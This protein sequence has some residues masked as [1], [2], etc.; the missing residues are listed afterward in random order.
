MNSNKADDAVLAQLARQKIGFIGA[1]R[2]ARAL[3]LALQGLG[4]NI[5]AVAS[6]SNDSA[7]ALADSLNN[8]RVLSKQ[9]LANVADLV[10][11][12]TPDAAI[13]P[14]VAGLNWHQ[15]QAVVHCSGA[16]EVQVLQPAA[17]CGALIGGFHPMQSFGADTRAAI[18]SLPGCAIAIEASGQ[19]QQFLFALAQALAC[20]PISLP[21]GA[22][23]R[24]HASGG[25]AA[26]K[27][28]VMLAEAIKLWLSW[29]ASEEQ[30][31]AALIPLLRGTV[32]S[33]ANS[34]V[35]Q[36]MPGPIS[37]GD[38]QT[39][40]KHRQALNSISPV[41]RANY[42]TLSLLAVDLAEQAGKL[43]SQQLQ[44]LR[45]VLKTDLV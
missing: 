32:E 20:K 8:C 2:L 1:G 12:S 34:G 39:V 43:D 11:I 7:S 21:A 30:A 17:D 44:Q 16:T 15:G 25:Y 42:D 24:Y 38:Y 14:T 35:A 4:L 45:H 19:L 29:G 40:A 23:A 13:E 6:R 18:A 5:Y 26:D 10:F 31:L 41:M 22:R 37:R 36:G 27:V 3:A 28:H 9:D 33:L